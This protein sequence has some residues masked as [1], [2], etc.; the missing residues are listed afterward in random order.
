M[1]KRKLE[2]LRHET[3]QNASSTWP[4]FDSMMFLE[5]H[6]RPRKSYKM[7]QRE[8]MSKRHSDN[9]ES[10]ITRDAYDSD[11]QCQSDDDV[12]FVYD[13]STNKQE[14]FSDSQDE[15]NVHQYLMPEI[16]EASPSS[17]LPAPPPMKRQKQ[18]HHNDNN[19]LSIHS[20]NSYA[21]NHQ[22]YQQSP[23]I[24]SRVD[25][26]QKFGNFIASSL[27]DLPEEQALSLIEKFTMDIVTT[28]KNN[29][30]NN[31]VS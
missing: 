30:V 19:H 12:H 24:T 1:E 26:Y 3:N 2:T 14:Q 5:G 29:I 25:K 18:L 6:I 4:L 11:E 28:M 21:Q 10:G 23:M 27:S 20:V 8:M 15:P 7:I 31:I 13:S 9:S 16:S 17:S 22:N